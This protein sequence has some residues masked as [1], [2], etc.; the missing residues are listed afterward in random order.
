MLERKAL[1]KALDFKLGKRNLLVTF[2]PVTLE[3]NKSAIQMKEL[4]VALEDRSDT[5][6]IFT[7]PNADTESRELF[8]MIET[9]VKKHHG[10]AKSF[11]SL[12][13]LRY[14]SCLKYMDGVVGNSSSGILEAPSFKIGTINI[15]NRQGGRV[16]AKSI[17]NCK[18][19]IKYL[20]KFNSK[21]Q[22]MMCIVSI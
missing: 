8:Q 3:Y 2:H 22:F 16:Q 17:I 15:G 20:F 9:F 10:R 14:L 1:E 19:I 18:L 7:M 4:L 21:H 12:G 13:H 5:K 11:T 6:I